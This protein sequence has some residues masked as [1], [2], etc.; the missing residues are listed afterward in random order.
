[1]TDADTVVTQTSREQ[2]YV[3]RTTGADCGL[4]GYPAVT[5]QGPGGKALPITYRRQSGTTAAAI[6]LS[7]ET[8]VSFSVISPRSGGCADATTLRVVLPGTG[9]AKVAPTTA[10]I[11]QGQAA[12]SPV[13]R[14][15]ADS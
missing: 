3:V 10:R 13:R 14:L 6:S 8:S 11:C 9:A 12:V 2:V 7:K 15:N 1:M 4:K 5:L